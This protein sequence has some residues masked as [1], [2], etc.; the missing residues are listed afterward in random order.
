MSSTNVRFDYSAIYINN[1]ELA[2]ELESQES[3][4]QRQQYRTS[5]ETALVLKKAKQQADEMLSLKNA[6]KNRDPNESSKR[7]ARSAGF[8]RPSS[9]KMTATPSKDEPVK[10]DEPD[11]KSDVNGTL[12]NGEVTNDG[13]SKPINNLTM[14]L[15][16][17]RKF[18]SLGTG[19]RH[20]EKD[21]QSKEENSRPVK[22]SS[23]K[24]NKKSCKESLPKR[25]ATVSTTD[26][27]RLEGQICGP[28]ESLLSGDRSS[29]YGIHVKRDHT[30]SRRA[31]EE[32][33]RLEQESKYGYV[34]KYEERRKKLLATCKNTHELENRI[35]TFLT[36]IDEFKKVQKDSN[37]IEKVIMR[38]KSAQLTRR[39]STMFW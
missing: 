18:K 19:K 24:S 34:N 30:R 11:S 33:S 2:S 14:F 38:A 13:G 31:L 16:S 8:K 6:L 26:S 29:Q 20:D 1:D 15:H 9:V 32:L 27:H 5:V 3:S 35:Q 10:T 36:G 12:A 39:K 7:I 37:S 4:L 17:L 25:P 21:S 23:A 28:L 22:K